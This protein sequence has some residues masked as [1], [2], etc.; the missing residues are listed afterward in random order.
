MNTEADN[1][2]TTVYKL[3]QE[4]ELGIPEIIYRLKMVAAMLERVVV[5]AV[6][7]TIGEDE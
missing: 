1:F 5:E 4:S 2:T 7:E 6:Y 3:C